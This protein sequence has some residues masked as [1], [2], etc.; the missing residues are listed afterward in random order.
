MIRKTII[1]SRVEA[2]KDGVEIPATEDDYLNIGKMSPSSQTI[3]ATINKMEG[4]AENGLVKQES[5]TSRRSSADSNYMYD[6][7][8][9]ESDVSGSGFSSDAQSQSSHTNVM[10]PSGRQISPL[11]SSSNNQIQIISRTSGSSTSSMSDVAPRPAARP[12][13][14]DCVSSSSSSHKI[15]E[16]LA[17]SRSLGH[18]T[19][20]LAQAVLSGQNQNFYF[21]GGDSSSRRSSSAQSKNSNSKLTCSEDHEML[22]SASCSR[23]NL[24]EN[25]EVVNQEGSSQSWN[26]CG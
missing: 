2:L 7:D 20:L 17:T 25:S 10:Q 18:S 4:G 6:Y 24:V 8:D 21:S 23:I 26:K 12:K 19:P 9:Y 16:S 3:D 22:M 14:T 11:A 5:K 1:D 15:S 13:S